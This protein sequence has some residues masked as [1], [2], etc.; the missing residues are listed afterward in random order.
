[1]SGSYVGG[2]YHCDPP[3][4]WASSGWWTV[5]FLSR[6]T[7]FATAAPLGSPACTGRSSGPPNLNMPAAN[8]RQGRVLRHRPPC[9]RGAQLPMSDLVSEASSRTYL[10]WNL[11]DPAAYPPSRCDRSWTTSTAAFGVAR[12]TD[13]TPT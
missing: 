7:W 6:E 10:D 12:R 1:M 5:T 13:P 2:A 8:P 4:A 9:G 3:A 11:P